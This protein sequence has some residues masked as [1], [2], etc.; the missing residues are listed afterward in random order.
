LDIY[1]SFRKK[2]L[3]SIHPDVGDNYGGERNKVVNP[4]ADYVQSAY[5]NPF[6]EVFTTT[7]T[8]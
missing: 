1:F 3:A 5:Y 8:P 6:S 4:F 7:T 2:E